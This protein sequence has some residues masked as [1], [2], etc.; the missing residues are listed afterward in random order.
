MILKRK[1]KAVIASIMCAAMIFATVGCSSQEVAPE[2]QE[3]KVEDTA[4]KEEGKQAAL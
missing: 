4:T 2:P 3:T 1:A